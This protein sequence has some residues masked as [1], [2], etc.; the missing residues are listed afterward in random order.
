MSPY[1]EFNFFSDSV[2]ANL[3]ISSGVPLTL[4]DL[5][6]GRRAFLT[7]ESVQF[8]SAG[9]RI[10]RLAMQLLQN[11]FRGDSNRQRFD[12]YDPLAIAAVLQPQLLTSRSM[13]LAVETA[14]PTRK[15]EVRVT[16]NSGPVSV[17][18]Q[19]DARAFFALLNDL[20]SLRN[21]GFQGPAPLTR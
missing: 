5:H 9:S 14:D 2:A 7:R 10:G 20:F 21:P 18:E 1:A 6:A 17:V 15:G 11:W 19:V 13:A 16:A 4:V 3:V 12:F 8:A